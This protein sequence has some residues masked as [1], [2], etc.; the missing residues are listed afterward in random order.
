MGVG[1]G[2]HNNIEVFKSLYFS[3]HLVDLDY[4]WYDNRCRSIVSL[5]DILPWP[6]G[7][8]GSKPGSTGQVLEKKKHECYLEGAVLNQSSLNFATMIILVNSRPDLKLSSGQ[9]LGHCV[10]S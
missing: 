6:I 2:V 4:I 7:H 10:S 8:I 9:K 5:S 3:N 1:V